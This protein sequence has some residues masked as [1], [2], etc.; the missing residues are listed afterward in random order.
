MAGGTSSHEAWDVWLVKAVSRV[1]LV[2]GL[3]RVVFTEITLLYEFVAKTI[4][5]AGW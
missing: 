3:A 2:S 5:H 1:L 4:T